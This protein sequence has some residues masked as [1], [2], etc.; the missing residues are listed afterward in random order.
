MLKV[1][2]NAGEYLKIGDNIKIYFTGG[3]EHRA[4]ILIDAPKEI[5]VA[6]S[7]A[8]VKHGFIEKDKSRLPL[9][10]SR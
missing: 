6:R 1:T 7:T 4:N 5:N 2:I 9:Y 10:K 3:N 8:L